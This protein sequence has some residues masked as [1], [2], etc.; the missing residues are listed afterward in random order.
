MKVKSL[1][2]KSQYHDSVALMLVARELIKLKGVVDAAVLMG[3]DSNKT[4][5]E[6]SGLLTPEAQAAGANDLV[7][8]IKAEVP[9][10]PILEKAQELLYKRP[11]SIEGGRFQPKTLRGAVKLKPDANLA[12]ISV[13]GQYAAR[14]A[15]GALDQKLHVLLFSDNVSLEDEVALKKMALA[16]GLLLMGPGAGTAIINGVGLGFANAVPLG[17]VGIVSAAGTGLQEVSTL[18]AKQG[19]GVSQAIG[20]GGR[21]LSKEVGGLMT[22]ASLEALQKDPATKVLAVISKPPNTVVAKKLIEKS[23]KSRKPTVI[24]LLGVDFQEKPAPQLH[25]AH[26]L[27]ETAFLAA[28]LAGANITGLEKMINFEIDSLKETASRFRTELKPKQKYLRGLF[29]GGTLCYEAQVIWNKMLDQTVLSNAPVDKKNKLRDSSHSERH[30]AIDLGEEE[31]TIGRPHP[32]IDNDLRIRR[33]LQ[34]SH[35]FEVAVIMLDVVLGYGAHPD[36]ASELG[37]A[38]KQAINNAAKE[39]RHLAIIASVIGTEKDPQGLLHTENA[40]QAAGAVVCQSNAAA[41]RLTGMIIS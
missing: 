26:T 11:T 6:Q 3:S 20:V 15:R 8:S 12:I 38:I 2:K 25:F 28:K 35:D 33:L 14:E 16:K 4:L 30:T 40:L 13:A 32:M 18:L 5:L 41:T 1:I 31:F 27:Q 22:F 17:P 7:I 21:D 29:S 24:C 23:F 36:P 34:E 39:S 37:P 9:V 19:I 10:E